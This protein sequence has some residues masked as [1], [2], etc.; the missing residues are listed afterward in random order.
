VTPA[1]RRAWDRIRR[2]AAT[3][4]PEIVIALLRA[5]QVLRDRIP[6]GEVERL[7]R[8][9]LI[10]QA[11]NAAAPAELIERL[12]NPASDV[13]T[14]GV[15]SSARA[16]IPMLPPRARDLVIAFGQL[17]PRV[18][19]AIRALDS[20]SLR[21]LVPEIRQAVRDTV[22]AGIEAGVG[23]RVTARQ[24]REIIGLAPNQAEAVRNFR[25]ALQEGDVSKA[26]GYQL[27][28]R[29]FDA[30]VRGGQLSAEQVDKMVTRYEQRFVAFNAETH[31]RSAAIEAQKVGQRIAWQEAQASGA[32]GD[33]EVWK[34]WVTTLDGR[35]RDSHE[36]MNGA[37]AR[38]DE[39]YSSGQMYP[40]EGEYN[41]RCVET[42]FV[43]RAA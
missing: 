36:E 42:Y 11:V 13:L 39:P 5:F 25:R 2:R 7:L 40:G 28:D 37:E 17:D 30:Q 34:R 1:E 16:N 38:L 15:V 12:L 8:A 19:D 6:V 20:T 43:R 33:G 9:G 29:R 21:S 14:E 22:Q 10:D 18:V 27:R 24:L 3:L 4:S 23:P 35:Q 32:L 26:L 31:A 41:C